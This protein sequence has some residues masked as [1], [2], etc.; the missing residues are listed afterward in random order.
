MEKGK[1]N[2]VMDGQWGSTG[3]GKLAGYLALKNDIC[4]SVCDFMS[5]AGHTWVS[6]EGKKIVTCQL[7]TALV[8]DDAMLLINAGSAITLT[9]LFKELD[10]NPGVA[11]RLMIHPNT[12]IITQEDRDHEAK[13]L[14]QIS[15]TLKGCGGSLS[16]KVMRVAKLA[17]D[18]PALK[19]FIGDTTETT[20]T[21]LKAGGTILIEGAQGFDLSLNHGYGYPYCTSRDVTTMSILNNAGVPPH[22]LGDVYG[23]LRT[24][25]IRVGNMYDDDGNEI[26]HSGP[27]YLDHEELSWEDVTR[28]SG[29]P[30]SDI[31]K[32]IERT[33]VTN[34][35]RRVFSFSF[36]QLD[37]FIKICSPTKLF[38]NFINHINA[39]DCGVRAATN[40]SIE[41]SAWLNK[42]GYHINNKKSL[43]GVPVPDISHVGTGPRNS[44]M[45]EL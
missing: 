37:R 23:S 38:V 36:R 6:D 9:Q 32:I 5:N 3:K 7:P 43:R 39:N 30:I 28:L 8:N 10:E 14:S 44:E 15:S 20:H 13:V 18:E 11:G 45:V 41:S 1:V 16:R 29:L 27:H 4:A 26:G 17:K 31:D 33:T 34:K 35:I 25:P 19:Q 2:I 40:L 12:T 24:Y 42:L 21:F 22:Y